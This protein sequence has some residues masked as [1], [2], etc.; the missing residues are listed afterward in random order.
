MSD[1]T[2][3]LGIRMCRDKISCPPP[4]LNGGCIET[5]VDN[6]LI[7]LHLPRTVTAWAL[8]VYKTAIDCTTHDLSIGSRRVRRGDRRSWGACYT[9]ECGVVGR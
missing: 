5:A 6:N 3:C 2:W 8:V 1:H 9:A 4:Q 7:G